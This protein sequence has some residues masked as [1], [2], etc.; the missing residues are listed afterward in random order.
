MPLSSP[1]EPVPAVGRLD[2]HLAGS[3]V[4]G[5]IDHDAKS[6][7]LVAGGLRAGLEADEQLH[8]ITGFEHQ[9]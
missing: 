8:R 3:V 5:R 6:G 1:T 9:P 2:E 4:G 7:R